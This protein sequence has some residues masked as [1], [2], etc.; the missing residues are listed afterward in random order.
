MDK[1]AHTYGDWVTVTEATETEAG[2]RKRTCSVCGYEQTEEIS[3][4]RFTVTVRNG[5]SSGDKSGE[6]VT[7][8]ADRRSSFPLKSGRSIPAM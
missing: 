1:A 6:T 8:T 2:L 4:L 5:S 3:M 7:I